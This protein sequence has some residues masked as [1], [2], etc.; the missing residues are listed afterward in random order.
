MAAM[1]RA[2]YPMDHPLVRR[3]ADGNERTSPSWETLTERLIR[4]AQER[5]EFDD[6]PARGRR[7]HLEDDSL[8]G[9]SALAHH[10][11]R[12]AGMAPPWIEADKEVRE[13]RDRIEV[14]I[15]RAGRAPASAAGR[16]H[17]E[18]EAL[19]D[20]HDESVRRLDGLAP[21]SRQQRARLER[22]TLHRRLEAALPRAERGPVSAAEPGGPMEADLASWGKVITL[23]TTGRTSG[24]P[25]RVTVGY[26]RDGVDLLVAASSEDTQWARN[27]AAEP[28]CVVELSGERRE[29]SA[30]PLD[31]ADR[32]HAVVALI[33]KYGTPAERLGRGPAFRLVPT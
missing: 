1:E 27:L 20:A 33:L 2:R 29:H 6:L 31:E 25:R 24:Q 15:K 10:V 18:L 8:A 9:E 22:A 11:L 23:E 5:G 13:A 28:R 17:R 4:E 16:L 32:A 21:T 14:L 3:D 30:V 26:A 12:N 7:L 19:S